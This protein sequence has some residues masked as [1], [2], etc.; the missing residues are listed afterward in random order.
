VTKLPTQLK[1]SDFV[2]VLKT[3]KCEQLRSKGGSA[4]HFKRLRD[5][6]IL[7]F[8]QPHGSDTLRQGTLSEYLRK[9]GITRDQFEDALSPVIDAVAAGEDELYRRAIDSDGT[10]ISNCARCFAVILKSTIEEEVLAAEMAH[11]CP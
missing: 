1:W 5:G 8:H 2:E 4:R 10:I 11:V 3:L 6:E 7:T 9:L